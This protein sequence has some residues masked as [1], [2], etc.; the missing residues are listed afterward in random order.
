MEEINMAE[1]TTAWYMP[2]EEAQLARDWIGY[3][4]HHKDETH[5]HVFHM[6]AK[7]GV[8][9]LLSCPE[10]ARVSLV[11]DMRRDAERPIRDPEIFY[12]DVYEYEGVHTFTI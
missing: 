3:C 11:N 4:I 1:I 6:G 2:L 10:S 12:Y 7:P 9:A 5:A 8:Y